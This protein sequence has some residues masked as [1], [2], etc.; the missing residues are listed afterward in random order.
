MVEKK[1]HFVY[2]DLIK[3]IATLGVIAIH[4]FATGFSTNVGSCNWFVSVIGDCSVRW[5]VPLFVMVSGVLFLQPTKEVSYGILL[6]KYIPRL[7]LAYIFWAFVYCACNAVRFIML[8]RELSLN[9]LVHVFHLWYIPMIIGVYLLIPILRKIAND[10]NLIKQILIL[11]IFYLIGGFCKLQ[12]ITHIGVIFKGNTIIEF[13]GYFLLGY[14][15]SNY[16]ITKKQER[17][18][19]VIGII[20]T[21]ICVSANLVR[22]YIS[23]VCENSTIIGYTTPPIVAMSL[24]LFVFVKQLTPKIEHKVNKFI[25]YV[26][27]DLFGIYLTH[28]MWLFV[29]NIPIFR[30]LCSHLI[31]LPLISIAIFIL[32]LYTTKLIR[33]IPLLK[34]TVE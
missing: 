9:L 28:L 4:V 2:V 19:Y 11:W 7:G 31:T 32:S 34:K 12:L 1:N 13:A 21:I 5:C 29:I 25:N 3:I 20:G 6:K 27:K 17:W 15:V 8:G 24:A 10:K 16:K 23:G 30:D 26:R 33:L 18:I 22:P 14:Y